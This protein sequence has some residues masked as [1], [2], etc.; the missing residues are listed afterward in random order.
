MTLFSDCTVW[1]VQCSYINIALCEP[2]QPGLVSVA[3]KSTKG[4]VHS[5]TSDKPVNIIIG[6][7]KQF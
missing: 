6:M 7:M 2:K 5:K 3:E 1:H 4:F